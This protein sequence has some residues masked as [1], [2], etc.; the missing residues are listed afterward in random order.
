MSSQ[1]EVNYESQAVAELAIEGTDYRID[2]G[3]QGTALCISTRPS[4]TWDWAFAAEARWD[5]S[6][7]RSKAVDRPVLLRLSD[8]LRSAMADT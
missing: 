7:L 6:S 4:G 2:S 1:G 5:G 3:K 8:A